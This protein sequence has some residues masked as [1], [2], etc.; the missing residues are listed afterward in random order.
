M[1]MP[2]NPAQGSRRRLLAVRLLGPLVTVLVAGLL[3]FAY[4]RVQVR[5]GWHP[6]L[7]LAKQTGDL[8][9]GKQCSFLSGG[10]R[11]R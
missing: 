6:Y 4:R 2:E 1:E 10:L 5:S 7:Q 11:V 8:K 9:G 3:I